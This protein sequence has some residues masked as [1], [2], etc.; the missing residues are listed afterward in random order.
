MPINLALRAKNSESS[1]WQRCE[2]AADSSNK[3]LNT[4]VPM[5]VVVESMSMSMDGDSL[6]IFRAMWSSSRSCE[7]MPDEVERE[8][9][10]SLSHGI[11][12]VYHMYLGDV[13]RG[14]R[15]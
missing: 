13:A 2:T 15:R 1:M 5:V 11:C 6:W 10:V 7:I 9:G 12:I 8:G 3:S 4:C 14:G